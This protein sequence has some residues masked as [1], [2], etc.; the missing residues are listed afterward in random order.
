MTTKYQIALFSEEADTQIAVLRDTVLRKTADLGI[1]PSHFVFLGEHDVASCDIKAPIVGAYLSLK[2]DPPSRSA[3]ADLVARG[4]MIVPVVADLTRFSSYVFEELRPINGMAFEAEDPG[5][6]SVTSILLEGLGLLRKTRR[7]FISYRRIETQGV[8]IQLYELLDQHGFDVFLDTHSIR[9]GEPF[10]DVLWHR[11]ADTDVIVLLDS[12]HF[13]ESRW[14]EQE[15][16]KA[17]STNVQILQ[18]MWPS[19]TLAAPA[20]FSRAFPLAPADFSG[21]VTGSTARLVPSTAERVGIEVESLR[22]RAL[23]ARQAYLIEEFCEEAKSVG[24]LPQVQPDRSITFESKSGISCVAVPSVGVPDAVRYQEIEDTLERHKGAKP[25]LILLYD[26]RGIR[27]NW[28]RHL[29]WLNRQ[30]LRVQSVQVARA[31][32]WLAGLK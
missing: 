23:A 30:K 7:L 31:N 18:L 28:V 14:T 3:I 8:A 9:P 21:D 6:E 16:A 20:A 22:A 25:E 13:M 15:L 1:D 4:V 26:E 32:T 29:D 12:P 10:Q 11:L 2:E 17:N 19:K 24:L 27:N 5:L